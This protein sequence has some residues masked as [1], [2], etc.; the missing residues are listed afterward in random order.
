MDGL[1]GGDVVV[2]DDGI[3]IGGISLT[4]FLGGVC[5]VVGVFGERGSLASEWNDCDGVVVGEE[6]ESWY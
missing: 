2:V 4:S 5:L 1:A 6:R 3:E